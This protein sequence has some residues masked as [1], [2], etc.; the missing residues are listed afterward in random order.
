M[1]T[2]LIA[3]IGWWLCLGWQVRA[4]A[5]DFTSLCADRAA[6]ERVYYNHRSGEKSPFEQTLPEAALE[7]LVRED[8]VKEAALKKVYGVE[9]TPALL[10]AE[11][12]RINAS[13]RAPEML[14]EIKS[15]LGNNPARFANAFAKPFLVERLFAPEIRLR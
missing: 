11:V 7:K 2:L 6:I 8:Q 15:A 4:R 12:Q 13:T 9:I 10:E 1:R 3:V 5:D 14:N